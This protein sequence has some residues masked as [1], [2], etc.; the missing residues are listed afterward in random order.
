[1]FFISIQ[2]KLFTIT[3]KTRLYVVNLGKT[4]LN[5]DFLSSFL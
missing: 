2:I 3:K 1:M 5:S 4:A